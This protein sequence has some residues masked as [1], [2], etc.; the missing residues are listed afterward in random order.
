MIEVLIL[1]GDSRNEICVV[2]YCLLY[3][4][5]RRHGSRHDSRPNSIVPVYD[6]TTSLTNVDMSK[7]RKKNKE[8]NKGRLGFD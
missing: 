1:K 2:E 4:S 5:G 6:V 3:S 8:R 7:K